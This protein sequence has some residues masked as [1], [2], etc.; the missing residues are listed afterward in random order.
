MTNLKKTPLH[1]LTATQI[2]AAVSA[3][4]TTC[5][6]VARACLERIAEREP[7]VQAW[8]YL[9]PDYVIKEAQALD[10]GSK[11]GPL[12]G[13]PY[14][15]KDIIDTADMPT[16]YGTPI[17][18]GHRPQR[19]AACVALSRKAGAVLMG[20]AVTSEFANVHPGKTRNPHDVTR[21]PG[22][23]SS[24]SGAA[25]GAEM[26]PLALG[27]QTTGSTTRPASFCGVVGYRPTWGDL[28]LN[29]VMEASGT[30]DTL[31][32]LARSVDDVAL[33]RDVLLGIEPQPVMDVD[34]RLRIG[35]CRTH[36]WSKVEPTTQKLLEDAAAR[37]TR[38]GATVED[39]TLPH[40]FEALEDAHRWISGFEMARNLT[41]EIENHWNEISEQFRNGRLTDGL[42]CTYEQYV[43]MRHHV[44]HCRKLL[45]PIL[46]RYDVLLAAAAPGEAPVGWHPVPHPWVYMIWTTM[47][48]PSITLPLF[49]GPNGLPVGAQLLTR[50]YDDHKLFAMAR[51]VDRQLMHA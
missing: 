35:F 29:G 22:G 38:A 48:V 31:G 26:V 7:T 20:K 45:L 49:K 18:K 16:E 3:G 5:E 36:N 1:S 33:Y 46:D 23:S 17:H 30:L 11:R 34:T 15:V 13:V 2:V 37:L 44:H 25:V 8:Q 12:I 24:G 4:E 19:D 14:G 43:A 51:W 42:A 41:W 39:V 9:D 10:K 6:A 50:H 32:I 28:R 40:E 21:T 27:T 47:H